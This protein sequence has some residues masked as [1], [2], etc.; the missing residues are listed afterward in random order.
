MV[1]CVINDQIYY[2]VKN[3]DKS[4]PN[5]DLWISINFSYQNMMEYK[6]KKLFFEILF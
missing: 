5:F 6:I 1:L 3:I 2:G 4:S